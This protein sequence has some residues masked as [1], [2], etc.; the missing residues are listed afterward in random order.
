MS[1]AIRKMELHK[2]QFDDTTINAVL[3]SVAYGLCFTYHFSL[4][5][6]PGQIIFGQDMIIN[7]VY[8]AKWKDLQRRSKM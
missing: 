3:Q 2:R 6:S 5:A 1:Y 7:A 4:A 8:L